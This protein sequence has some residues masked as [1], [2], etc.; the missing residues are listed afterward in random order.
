MVLFPVGAGR[1]SQRMVFP[2][3][4]PATGRR[5]H[6]ACPK[7]ATGIRILPSSLMPTRCFASVGVFIFSRYPKAGDFLS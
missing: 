1:R 7:G 5:P 2:V 4:A 3:F 6:V